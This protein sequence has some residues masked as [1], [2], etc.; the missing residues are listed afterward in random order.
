MTPAQRRALSA[1]IR[2][3]R[4]DLCQTRPVA[5]AH[6]IVHAAVLA[7][8]DPSAPP[9]FGPVSIPASVSAALSAL[10]CWADDTALSW[11]HQYFNDP[12]REA[13]TA[14]LRA[15]GRIQPDEIG[16]K[17]QLFTE[18]YLVSWILQNTLGPIWFGICARNGWEPVCV[19]SGLLAALD[20]WRTEGA[21]APLPAGGARWLHLLGAP[22]P[23]DVG[24]DSLRALRLLDPA[25]GSGHFLVAA[26]ELL[27]PLFAEEARHRGEAWRLSDTVR[28]ICGVTLHGVDI[29]PHAVS[30]A[31]AVLQL[32]ARRMG[33]S[34]RPANL[35]TFA[36]PRGTLRRDLDLPAFH[37]VVGNPPYQGT[38]KLADATALRAAYPL[39]RSDL[40]AA[41]LLRGLE[42]VA[43]GGLSGMLTLR[44]WMFT[45]HHAKM[46]A[47]LLER[48]QLWALCDVDTGAFAEI[49]GEVVR[50]AASIFR[51][52]A[53][54]GQ[55]CRVL[56]LTGADGIDG[57]R[58]A[59]RRQQ[60]RH[61]FVPEALSAIPG[62][63]LVYR[64]DAE[65]L[66]AYT[67]AP[68]LGARFEI[69]QGLCTGDNTRFLR[70]PWEVDAAQIPL[71]ATRE[72]LARPDVWMPF[73]KGGEGQR[74]FE[75]LRWV[76][77]WRRSGLEIRL[78]A[79]AGTLAARPQN[80]GFYTT[81]GVAVQT[82]GGQF[83]GRLHAYPS[84]FG[85]MARSV[86]GDAPEAVTVLLNAA[87]TAAVADALNPTIH[88]TV[89]DLKRLPYT[90]DPEAA[91][92]M[93]ILSEAFAA[94]ERH[95]EPSVSFVAPGPTPWPH[96]Q[97][98][99]RQAIDRPAG[100]PLPP[101]TPRLTPP[102]EA[103]RLSFALGVALGRFPG[104]A[105][106]DRILYLDAETEDDSLSHPAAAPLQ[107]AW[108]RPGLRAFLCREAF[109]ALHRR[110]YKSR[111][112]FW[113]LSSPGRQ[114]VAWIPAHDADAGLAAALR[115][116]R[117]GPDS[118]ERAA[119]VEM[120]QA[121]AARGPLSLADG[122]AVNLAAL[123]PLLSPQWD[124][125]EQWWAKL[126]A[127]AWDWSSMAARLW[128]ER[129]A[130]RC[131]ADPSMAAAHG[132]LRALHPQVAQAWAQKL[133]LLLDE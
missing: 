123:W 57:K 24:I 131:V 47:A 84:V 21:D 60:Q 72:T 29:D 109:E 15:G 115:R 86:F 38:A 34:A 52:A 10:D 63:P 101:Y 102:T 112:I 39:G 121:A 117:S 85:D 99:A 79:A 103:D 119:L 40:Y 73:L 13:I 114:I 92:I 67:A 69:R 45:R 126:S 80:M 14:R 59:A 125:P 6:R 17:T 23:A 120:L 33:V 48:H 78:G 116:A 27:V 74:W 64:W 70:R 18:R 66:R 75:P 53:P 106:P 61:D 133:G 42:L 96:A 22:R 56:D 122:V 1:T 71:D 88:V 30:V 54:D 19:S 105:L 4:A 90:P 41:F 83:A 55:P 32:R 35:R 127:G 58:A 93:A 87:R 50:V 11:A 68:K 130:A 132:R 62:R 25:V 94:H 65:A 89:G 129:V 26:L 95:R 31:H 44:G 49:S 16:C 98:W 5:E 108:G 97:R 113:P 36:D 12:Q 8:L 82:L 3:L 76:V 128:P 2:Q 110:R 28:H 81:R 100:A 104:E 124:R 9:M 118:P 111:P 107:A 77:N 37:L 43:P 46:R 51:R 7:Q 20:R 91:A